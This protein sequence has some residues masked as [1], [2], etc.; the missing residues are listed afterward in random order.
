VVADGVSIP[1]G[2]RHHRCALVQDG[3]TLLV[4]AL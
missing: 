4:A 1:A 3:T 2:A